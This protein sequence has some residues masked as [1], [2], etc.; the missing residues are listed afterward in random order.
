MSITVN[1]HGS[2]PDQEPTA[3]YFVVAGVQWIDIRSGGDKIALFVATSEHARRIAEAINWRP[4][5]A[6]LV[7]EVTR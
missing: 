7:G 6:D 5:K 4:E 3:E 2:R 1:I